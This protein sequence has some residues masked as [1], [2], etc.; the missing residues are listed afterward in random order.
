MTSGTS[1]VYE[2]ALSEEDDVAAVLHEE[3][4]DL[5]LNV[6]YTLGTLLQ[7]GDIDLNI[8]VTNV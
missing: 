8:E 3:S 5:G 6:L 1:Q 2:T 7:P 4:V